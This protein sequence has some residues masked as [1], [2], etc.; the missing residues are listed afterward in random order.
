MR[1]TVY[2]PS[3]AVIPGAGVTLR[4]DSTGFSQRTTSGD[5]GEYRFLIV[6]PGEYELEFSKEYVS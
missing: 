1:G 6:P 2:D 5:D 3:A 4:R